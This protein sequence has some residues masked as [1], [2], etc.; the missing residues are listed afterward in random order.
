MLAQRL[1][2]AGRVREGLLERVETMRGKALKGPM[3][4]GSSRGWSA[5]YVISR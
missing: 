5:G 2:T 3:Y 4:S 1:H